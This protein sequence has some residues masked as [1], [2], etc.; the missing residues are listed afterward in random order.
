VS[1]GLDAAYAAAAAALRAA[2]RVAVVTHEQPDGD[3][4]GSLVGCVRG[5]R[6]AG[7]AATAHADPEPFPREF[8]WLDEGDI[9]RAGLDGGGWLLLAV[10]C[11][12]AARM[13]APG[14]LIEGAAQIVNLDHHHDNTHFGAIDIVDS[15]AACSAM[16]VHELL[17]RLGGPIPLAVAVPLYVGLVTDTGRFQYSNTGP[18]AFR[19]AA[20]LVEQGVEPQAV[21][22]RV[23]ENVPAPKLRL[24]GRT[25]GRIQLRLDGRLALSWVLR[26]D[27]EEEGADD[28]GTEGVIDQLRAIAGVEVAALVR[29]PPSGPRFKVSLRSSTDAIDVS[30]IARAGGGGGH[31]R[32]AGFSSD[33][34][35]DQVLDFIERE[36]AASG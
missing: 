30:R 35:L 19:F 23:Y 7:I 26:A 8:G 3:A 6:L 17:R 32:A 14:G 5:L 16:M 10:D 22:A 18:R 33:L 9:S 29:E 20:D 25:L 24:L 12:S 1:D 2:G 21:F 15:D 34:E 13:A 36:V 11:G 27:I 31:P 4:L 28:A